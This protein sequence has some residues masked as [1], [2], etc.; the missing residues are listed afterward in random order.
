MYVTWP[1]CFFTKTGSTFSLHLFLLSDT[2]PTRRRWAVPRKLLTSSIHLQR[3]TLWEL[4]A[5]IYCLKMN[6]VLYFFFLFE[7]V[8]YY[9]HFLMKLGF[10]TNRGGCC[11]QRKFTP[12]VPVISH[13]KQVCLWQPHIICYHWYCALCWWGMPKNELKNKMDCILF[14][15]VSPC[16]SNVHGTNLTKQLFYW[17]PSP[18]CLRCRTI[19]HKMFCWAIR[20]AKVR[21]YWH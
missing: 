7:K 1:I 8:D 15:I 13:E 9:Y 12:P 16:Q 17:Q 20:R 5:W 10:L 2:K 11:I 21:F 6:C 18:P 4:C 3:V 14:C 19:P